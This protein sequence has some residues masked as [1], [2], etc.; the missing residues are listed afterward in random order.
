MGVQLDIP[1]ETLLKLIE[2]LPEAQKRDLL[3]HLEKTVQQ[4]ELSADEWIALLRSIQIHKPILEEPSIRREDWYD[5]D[6]R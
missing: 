5:D 1:Y 4:R 3:R 6:G 2:Q